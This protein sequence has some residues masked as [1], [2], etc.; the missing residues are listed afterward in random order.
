MYSIREHVAVCF[1]KLLYLGGAQE[2]NVRGLSTL[3]S[4]RSEE[5]YLSVKSS[6][7]RRI[8]ADVTCF[9]LYKCFSA[10][11]LVLEYVLVHR[12]RY[13]SRAGKKRVSPGLEIHGDQVFAVIRM[14]VIEQVLLVALQIIEVFTTQGVEQ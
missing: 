4:A 13:F 9:H 1:C 3:R 11:L 8:Q 14:K 2:L 12:G 7:L 5:I 10:C 6:E